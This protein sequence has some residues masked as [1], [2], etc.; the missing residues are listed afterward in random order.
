MADEMSKRLEAVRLMREA[1]KLLD[2]SNKEHGDR[3]AETSTS[4]E[5]QKLFAPYRREAT[6]SRQTSQVARPPKPPK[7]QRGS[8]APMFNP[9]PTWTHRFCLLADKNATVAPSISEKENLKEMGLGEQK[10]TFD[11]KKGNHE[12]LT[13]V[14]EEKFPILKEGGGYLICRTA[15]GSQRLQVISPGGSGY[16]IP[17]L[18]DDSPLRQA[19][20]YIRPLQKSIDTSHI[21]KVEVLL[22]I[23][24]YTFSR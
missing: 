17:H 21:L 23:L 12:Y 10:I 22:Y 6:S 19:V 20:A 14:L 16:S 24:L 15:A 9:L 2:D 3:P 7:R 4:S 11:D 5:M 8:W 18:R 13:R 1:A